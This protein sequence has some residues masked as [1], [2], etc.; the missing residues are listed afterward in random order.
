TDAPRP[1]LDRFSRRG[2]KRTDL[3][4]K[5]PTAYRLPAAHALNRSRT[6][7]RRAPDPRLPRSRC[8]VSRPPSVGGIRKAERRGPGPG[9]VQQDWGEELWRHYSGVTSR[10]R[11]AVL[12]ATRGLPSYPT[13]EPRRSRRRGVGGMLALT[14]RGT[15]CHASRR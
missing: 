3:R 9:E 13:L 15:T 12:G 2:P 1:D 10:R 6:D 5:K 4:R 11:N 8:T 7:A 14:R